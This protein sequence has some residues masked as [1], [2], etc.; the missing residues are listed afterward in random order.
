MNAYLFSRVDEDFP[1]LIF[2]NRLHP[3]LGF[4]GR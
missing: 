3:D 1:T 2:V 4:L